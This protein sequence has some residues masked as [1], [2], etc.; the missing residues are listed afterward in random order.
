MSRSI[1]VAGALLAVSLLVVPAARAVSIPVETDWAAG[2][3]WEHHDSFLG[4]PDTW[5]YV[6]D[7]FSPGVPDRRGA[8]FHLM[9]CGQTT[10]QVAQGAGWPEAAEEYGL[11]VVVPGIIAPAHPNGDAPNV[12]CFNYGYDGAYGVYEP[13]RNDPDH[14]ALIAAGRSLTADPDLAHLRVDPHQV[15]LAGMSAGG[16]VAVEVGCMAP[17]VF[18]GVATAASPGIGS[19]QGTA[20]MPPRF[21][22]SADSVAALCRQYARSSGLPDALDLLSLQTHAIVSDDNSLPAGGGPLDTSKFYDQRIWDGDKFCPHV[23]QEVRAEAFSD[24]LGLGAPALTSVAVAE[25]TG[26]GCPG[27]ERSH[28]DRDEVECQVNESVDREWTALADLWRDAEGRTRLV[29][30]EQDTL[31]H[32][33]PSG[34]PGPGDETVTPTRDDLRRDGY[35]DEDTGGF[36]RDLLNQAPNG[37]LGVIYLNERAMDFPL[38]VAELWADNSPRLAPPPVDDP[39]ED[40]PPVDDPPV[41]DPPEGTP[42]TVSLLAAEAGTVGCLTA[43]G[44]AEA[45][46][47]RSPA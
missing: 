25:G 10:F 22:F 32:T 45:P 42:P 28:D 1:P 36:T 8:V 37:M 4:F 19:A 12:E 24:L 35:I 44:E 41:D 15:Y 40:D 30:I 29:K 43:R 18:S 16:A 14:A 5:V 17:D 38:F 7:S 39:P 6:P 2:T 31:R 3:S 46:T 26:M 9:G 34:S 47:A 33:W 20:I 13:T 11:V 23:Y 27:G 21:G